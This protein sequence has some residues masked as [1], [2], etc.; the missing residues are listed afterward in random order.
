MKYVLWGIGRRGKRCLESLGIEN[1]V[2]IIDKDSNLF[3]IY[4]NKIPIISL[5]EYQIK[6][7]NFPIII[8]PRVSEDIVHELLKCQIYQFFLLSD[9]PPEII[10]RQKLCWSKV[11]KIDIAKEKK[12]IILGNTLYSFFVY[13]YLKKS[14]YRNIGILFAADAKGKFKEFFNYNY[15]EYN[16]I[17]DNDKADIFIQT[18]PEEV[19]FELN[20]NSEIWDWYDLSDFVDNYYNNNI[21]K[22]RGMY[23][24]KRCF[25]I[26]TGSSL[27]IE[28]LNLLEKNHEICIS[29]NKVLKIFDRTSWKPNYYVVSDDAMISDF[30]KEIV[31]ADIEAKFISDVCEIEG[32][33]K[34][35]NV[36]QYHLHVDDARK[37]K[38]K[39]S[40]DFA[41]KAYSGATVTYICM[42][43]AV[44]MGFK[45]IY[46]LG[47]DFDYQEGEITK[48]FIEDYHGKGEK[49]NKTNYKMNL[50][51]YQSA[52]EYAD[53]HNVEIYNATRGG[54]LEVFERVDF[55]N[56]F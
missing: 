37:E 26:A 36:Y 35:E 3:G 53:N 43:L 45:Q 49:A 56:L 8:T 15:S 20:N 42:Q 21:E 40:D 32:Y 48:H 24:N 54:K 6:Y 47:V 34:F 25:I 39:F 9:C 52:K 1:I 19:R 5:D 22:Y 12:I 27:T 23:K 18:V 31:E 50:L 33:K 29:M 44:Y 55:D 51:A 17:G 10:S 30:Y 28:D 7:Y 2:A 11:L 46:L 41:Q 14:G 16:Y 38:L 4:A 13:D